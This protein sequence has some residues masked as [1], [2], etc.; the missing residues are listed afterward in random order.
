MFSLPRQ[1]RGWLHRVSLEELEAVAVA[2]AEP[3]GDLADRVHLPVRSIPMS[4]SST[5]DLDAVAL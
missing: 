2:M 1:A 4:I 5:C 3:L